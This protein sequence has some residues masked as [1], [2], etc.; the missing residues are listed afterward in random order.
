MPTLQIFFYFNM[1]CITPPNCHSKKQKSLSNY[2]LLKNKKS[3]F[4]YY[5]SPTTC[6]HRK[7]DKNARAPNSPPSPPAPSFSPPSLHLQHG[8]HNPTLHQSTTI[9]PRFPSPLQPPTP[10]KR[11]PTPPLQ[12]TCTPRPLKKATPRI[13]VIRQ[14]AQ[15][16]KK[17]LQNQHVAVPIRRL[18]PG[19][20]LAGSKVRTSICPQVDTPSC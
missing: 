16:P 8:Q 4:S 15:R 9:R 1:C 6:R 7:R 10:P 13:H 12:P 2:H 20:K 17:D 14:R 18:F 5:L 11:V 19:T 3:L